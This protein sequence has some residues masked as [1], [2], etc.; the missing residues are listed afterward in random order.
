[1]DIMGENN[2]FVFVWAISNFSFC[3]NDQPVI[4]PDFCPWVLNGSK[5]RLAMYPIEEECVV[6]YMYMADCKVAGRMFRFELSFLDRD[7]QSYY[8]LNFPDNLEDPEIMNDCK[9]LID[10][11]ALHI[12]KRFLLLHDDTLTIRLKIYEFQESPTPERIFF[13]TKIS[14][15]SI[16]ITQIVKNATQFLSLFSNYTKTVFWVPSEPRGDP[17]LSVILSK[18]FRYDEPRIFFEIDPGQENP[19]R[20]LS[21]LVYLLGSNGRKYFCREIDVFLPGLFMRKIKHPFEIANSFILNN[22]EEFFP[23]D[24]LFISFEFKFPRD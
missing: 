21:C 12:D 14:T 8:Y 18:S 6:C 22:K 2:G 10:R 9:I 16:C 13:E 15:K 5:L 11:E 1:M 23:N 4:S 19:V 20:A 3:K 24:N 17:V 7:F